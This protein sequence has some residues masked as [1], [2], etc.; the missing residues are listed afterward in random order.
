MIR[1]PP[2]STLFPY[3][4]LFRSR[5]IRRK[6][7]GCSV[8]LGCVEIVVGAVRDPGLLALVPRGVAGL[9][10]RRLSTHGIDSLN[11]RDTGEYAAAGMSG[12]AHQ[13]P[14][15]GVRIR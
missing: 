12:G 1:R 7:P 14:R 8:T 13:Q 3:T 15:D 4:T 6:P 5:S 11:A 2:R 10:G 9:G